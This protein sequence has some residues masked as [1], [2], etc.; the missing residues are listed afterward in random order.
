MLVRFAGLDEAVESNIMIQPELAG[1]ND[2]SRLDDV[3]ALDQ[4]LLGPVLYRGG[5]ISLVIGLYAA[6]ADDWAQRFITLAGGISQLALSATVTTAVSMAATI[7]TSVE[8]ALSSDGL[9]LKLGLNMELKEDVSLRPGYLVMIAA[10]EDSIDTSALT[11]S[12][13]EVYTTGG[14]VFA[15]HDYLVLAVEVTNQRSDWQ[16]LGYGRLWQQLLKTAAE[17]DDIQVVKTAYMTFSGAV[18]AS[19]DLSWADRSAII[20]LAQKRLKAIREAR[21]SADFLDGMKSAELWLQIEDIVSAEA[22]LETTTDLL[23]RPEALETD[24]LS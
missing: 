23:T 22:L 8:N 16:G 24:W 2:T 3:V 9:D 7:K 12:D 17:A 11:I 6:P 10:P 1:D 4:T 18:M 13:G 21:N 5:D 20:A 15:D 14:K 19:P